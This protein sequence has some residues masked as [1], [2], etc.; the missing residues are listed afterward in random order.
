MLHASVRIILPEL[1]IRYGGYAA[2]YM[3]LYHFPRISH[4][5]HDGDDVS[6]VLVTHFETSGAPLCLFDDANTP[7]LRV[8]C[9]IMRWQDSAV[10][11]VHQ[12]W[13]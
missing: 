6:I 12:H 7:Y 8:P 3:N 1:L 10:P 11:L 9:M 5:P 13:K 4:S 2:N